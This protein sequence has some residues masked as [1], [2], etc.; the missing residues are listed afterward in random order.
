MTP[1]RE[2][3]EQYPRQRPPAKGK[4][5]PAVTPEQRNNQLVSMSFDAAE[6]MI[7]SGK[8]TSQLLVHFL[9]QQTARDNLE[10]AKLEKENLLLEART[11]QI[12]AGEDVRELYQEAIAAMT[13]YKGGAE[14][15]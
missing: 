1:P 8:A 7:M 14:Y 3:P 9:K 15:Q 6:T 10:L 4:R 2:D 13:E 11:S 5:A 12:S